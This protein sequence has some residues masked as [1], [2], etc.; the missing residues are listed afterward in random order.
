MAIDKSNSKPWVKITVWV[1]TIALMFAFMGTGVWFLI[2]NAGYLFSTD[3]YDE[4]QTSPQE[5]YEVSDE[6]MIRAYEQQI[7]SLEIEVAAGAT[8]EK[9]ELLA[10]MSAS[11]AYW[12]YQRGDVADFGRAIELLERAIEL[13]PANHQESGDIL[14]G[15]LQG[16]LNE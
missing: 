1:L 9:Q 15:Q 3:H 14:I 7:D 5:E 13:D 12:L 2:A 6:D 10:G 16:A 4:S 8:A 11:Y